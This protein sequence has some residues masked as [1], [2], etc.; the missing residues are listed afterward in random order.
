MNIAELTTGRVGP[1]NDAIEAF[2]EQEVANLTRQIEAIIGNAAVIETDWKNGRLP[3]PVT[4]ADIK[5]RVS[6]IKR[7]M[8]ILATIA[9]TQRAFSRVGTSEML[10]GSK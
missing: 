9:E 10:G 1:T 6:G 7:S 8:S 3:G 5:D 4:L 2:V